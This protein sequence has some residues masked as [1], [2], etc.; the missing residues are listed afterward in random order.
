MCK[1]TNLKPRPQP[2]PLSSSYTPGHCFSCPNHPTVRYQTTRD[3]LYP[4]L[5]NLKPAYSAPHRNFIHGRI[6]QPPNTRTTFN[7]PNH[8]NSLTNHIESGNH[9]QGSCPWFPSPSAS[10]LTCVALC[11]V[12]VALLLETVTNYHFNGKLS[13]DLSASPD[14]NNNKTYIFKQPGMGSGAAEN[15]TLF[16]KVLNYTVPVTGEGAVAGLWGGTAAS[17]AGVT[18]TGAQSASPAIKWGM[19]PKLLRDSPEGNCQRFLLPSLSFEP[20]EPF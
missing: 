15:H 3:I 16:S 18:C 4:K 20:L 17:C 19:W 12:T 5:A 1:S 14:L 6:S 7:Q 9:S 8:Q 11:D 2:P 10:W 13:P